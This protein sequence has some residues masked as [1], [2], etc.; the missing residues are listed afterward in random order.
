MLIYKVILSSS[1]PGY[2]KD[3]QIFFFEHW[4]LKFSPVL[5]PDHFQKNGFFGG[6]FNHLTL[7]CE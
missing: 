5:T 7:T 2:L 4:L 1:F 3:F 6:F